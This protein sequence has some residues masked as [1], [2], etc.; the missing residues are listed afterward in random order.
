MLLGMV[1]HFLEY[2]FGSAGVSFYL[3]IYPS[4]VHGTEGLRSIVGVAMHGYQ[5]FL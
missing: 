2:D 1:W 3:I 5:L 4:A